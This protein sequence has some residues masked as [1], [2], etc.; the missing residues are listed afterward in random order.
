MNYDKCIMIPLKYLAYDLGMDRSG[1]RKY[2]LKNGFVPRKI[3]TTESRHQNTLAVSLPE[4]E[5]I[6]E[7]RKAQ[8]FSLPVPADECQILR[9]TEKKYLSIGEAALQVGV[10]TQ[11]LRDWQKKGYLHPVLTPGKHRR[12]YVDQIKKVMG[13]KS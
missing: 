11:T 7:L 4:A 12:Y 3:R 5:Q 10:S 9:G 6:K 8:G 13:E 1:A 2:I